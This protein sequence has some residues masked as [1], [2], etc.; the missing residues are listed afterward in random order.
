MKKF[1]LLLLLAVFALVKADAQ[2]LFEISG[3]GLEK[4]SYIFGTHH[5]APLSVVEDYGILDKISGV[6]KVVGEVSVTDDISLSPDMLKFMVAPPD[7]TLS[8]VLSPEDYAFACEEFK[9]YSP[10]PLASFE[11]MRPMVVTSMIVLSLMEE[12]LDGYDEDNQ[13]D[14]YIMRKGLEMGKEVLGLETAAYQAEVLYTC[15]SI[16]EQAEALLEILRETQTM[17]E[18]ADKINE[19]YLTGDLEGLAAMQLEDDTDFSAKL[20][21]PRNADWLT[22]IPVI[23]SDGPALFAVGALHLVGD[24]GILQGLRNQGYTVTPVARN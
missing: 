17:A 13:M 6:D 2:L 18:E 22:K 21:D 24:N 15:F 14:L 8:K 3:N 7:S 1:I 23:I 19:F 5:L 10:I 12:S 9:K 4:P 20:V 16:E 11:K